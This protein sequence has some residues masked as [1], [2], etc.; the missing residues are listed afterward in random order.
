[1]YISFSEKENMKMLLIHEDDVV[2]GAVN[3]IGL[4]NLFAYHFTAFCMKCS[5][6]LWRVVSDVRQSTEPLR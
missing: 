5:A 1:M 3:Y 6:I 4:D 2:C